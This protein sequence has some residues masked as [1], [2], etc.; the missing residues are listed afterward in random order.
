MSAA[1]AAALM[2]KAALGSAPAV[3]QIDDVAPDCTVHPH[4]EV[5]EIQLD[6]RGV[7]LTH[8]R[9]NPGA[10]IEGTVHEDE[11]E[12]ILVLKGRVYARFD[13]K[14]HYG[15]PGTLFNIPR[16]A[17]HGYYPLTDNETVELLAIY[18]PVEA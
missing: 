4:V 11:H 2:L 7:H 10:V 12:T 5:R 8:V 16:G 13:G 1:T 17:T 9:M 18:M 14:D 15:E 3:W 6:S